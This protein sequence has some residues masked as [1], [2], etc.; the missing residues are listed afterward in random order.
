M[1]DGMIDAMSQPRGARTSPIRSSDLLPPP[2]LGRSLAFGGIAALV[3]AAAWGLLVHFSHREYGILAWAIGA[4]VG[5]AIVKGGG[6]GNLLAVAAGLLALASIGTGK[7]FGFQLTVDS[8]ASE[9]A[10]KIEDPQLQERRKDA[11]DW[12]ALGAEPT[13]EQIRTFAE[14]HEYDFTTRDEFLRVEGELLRQFHAAQ[15][16]LDQWRD[17][18]RGQITA[19]ASFVDYLKDDFHPA[20]L[21]FAGLGI[22]SAF[23]LVSKATARLRLIARQVARAEREAAE[24]E[25]PRDGATS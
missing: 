3:G 1:P 2:P 4:F 15:P 11:A 12:V 14:G 24:A 6:H 8:V 5:A 17:Q 21:L 10:G 23:G 7:H 25:Q 20:D 22:A 18:I 16:T 19:E 9:I 13:A